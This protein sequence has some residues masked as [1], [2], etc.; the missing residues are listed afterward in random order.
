[1]VTA[2]FDE[3]PDLIDWGPD[4][5]YFEAAQKTYVHMF[6]V[7]PENE[8][9]GEAGHAGSRRSVWIFA[10]GAI[11]STLRFA[12]HGERVRRNLC[13]DVAPWKAKKLTSLA[14]S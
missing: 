5:I 4:G 2:A 11:S 13:G 9:G 10:R 6:R 12:R 14:N 3:D 7:N 8:G 1:V